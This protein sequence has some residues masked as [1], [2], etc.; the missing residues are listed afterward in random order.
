[1]TLAL[2]K[3]SVQKLV[4]VLPASTAASRQR[5]TPPT[6]RREVETIRLARGDAAALEQIYRTHSR[7]VYGLC[8]RMTGNPTL[9]EDLTQDI[10]LQVFRKI[11]TFR[12]ESAFSTWLY[13]L[14]VNI[15]PMRRRMKGLKETVARTKEPNRRRYS[16]P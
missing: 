11:Q 4:P 12:A 10:F 16:S 3:P 8:F 6:E 1:M 7:R 9:A 2:C 14:A 15:V 5:Q 13:R